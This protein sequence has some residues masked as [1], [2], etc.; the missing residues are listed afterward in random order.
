VVLPTEGYPISTE[1]I[2]EWFR[3]TYNHEATDKEVGDIQAALAKRDSGLL[4]PEKDA[5]ASTGESEDDQR[6]FTERR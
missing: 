2:R 1:A 3:R 4:E 5:R 6:P